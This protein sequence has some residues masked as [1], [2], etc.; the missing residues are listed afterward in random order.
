ASDPGRDYVSPIFLPGDKLLF[1][2]N[3]IVEP[4]A[5]QHMDEYERGTTTQMGIM[6]ID[7]TGEELGARN[8]SHRTMPSL[9]SD[10]RVIF[11]QWD[12]LGPMNAGHLMFVNQDMTELRE[13]FGKEGTAASN[14]NVH[15]QE[16]SPG[17]FVVIA[18]S[19]NR[20]FNSG[21]LIDVRL[22]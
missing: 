9:A 21:A 10:G 22:G 2:T 18:T 15:A 8:L 14:S 11:T 3:S 4:G 12:H 7:G 17:R 19:R 6:N 20:T 1:T 16:I 13:A 5:P